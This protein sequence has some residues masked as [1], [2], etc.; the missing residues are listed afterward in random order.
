M[1]AAG[2]QSLDAADRAFI[3]KLPER[4]EVR[5]K[6]G[7]GG[8][9]V[10]F[11]AF[12]KKTKKK[13]ALKVLKE[14]GPAGRFRDRLAREF[15]VCQSIEHPNIVKIYDYSF[16]EGLAYLAMEQL[17]AKDLETILE[18]GELPLTKAVDIMVQVASA[19]EA[20]HGKGLVHR[21][22]KPENIMVQADGRAVLMDFNLVFAPDRTAITK[23]DEIV[24]TPAYFAPEVILQGTA[25]PPVD[26]YAL[27]LCFYETL[28]GSPAFE[29]GGLEQLVKAIMSDDVPCP[30]SIIPSLPK[31]VDRVVRRATAKHPEER[32]RSAAAFKAAL[33]SLLSPAARKTMTIEVVL[34]K[35]KRR[36]MSSNRRMTVALF[37]ALS[38]VFLLI[39]WRGPQEK[40][41]TELTQSPAVEGVAISWT[42]PAEHAF[43]IEILKAD[44]SSAWRS[45]PEPSTGFKHLFL[46][47]RKWWKP[48]YHGLITSA[49]SSQK[50]TFA[51]QQ[52]T[53]FKLQGPTKKHCRKG[54]W[55]KWRTSLPLKGEI[56]FEKAV[57]SGLPRIY[58]T[59]GKE[60]KV[61]IPARERIL[62]DHR[63]MLK[64]SDP[65]GG[66]TR[67][68]TETIK[69]VDLANFHD[70]VNRFRQ[71]D[72]LK[73]FLGK[74]VVQLKR[75]LLNRKRLLQSAKEV[76]PFSR[77]LFSSRALSTLD[78]SSLYSSLSFLRRVDMFLFASK[79]KPLF[80]WELSDKGYVAQGFTEKAPFDEGKWPPEVFL[81]RLRKGEQKFFP[82]P[83]EIDG[84]PT[85]KFVK[86]EVGAAA[87]RNFKFAFGPT[88]VD[89]LCF[90]DRAILY[91]HTRLK[92]P[93]TIL[94]IKINEALKVDLWE[95]ERSQASKERHYLVEMPAHLLDVNEIN[96]Q[97]ALI[98]SAK[99]TV[100]ADGIVFKIAFLP[101]PLHTWLDRFHRRAS[102]LVER[103][104]LSELQ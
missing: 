46:V 13:L 22:V 68:K 81:R 29:L 30:T 31:A 40:I 42:S 58:K 11:S 83:K 79:E 65:F 63:V 17:E 71:Q 19:L 69:A 103:I 95:A 1:V 16:D 8:F 12:D 75:E 92:F 86:S 50:T 9:S 85:I 26:I 64:V 72:G 18:K 94:T 47:P 38:L 78:Q 66:W 2:I 76:V 87:V 34:P 20:I 5:G 57:R 41:V 84:L 36:P 74:P 77:F 97:I 24:G 21:D 61:L 100:I 60:H 54:T 53:P 104:R 59:E 33:L 43:Q 3:E 101:G 91:L 15:K 99:H 62:R 37:M 7:S 45:P 93:D 90:G 49:E 48:A 52:L 98:P 56:I 80:G 6:L 27:G 10:V 35:V 82:L 73:V 4:Y 51:L 55:L 102:K 23:S 44:G 67:T 70:E 14:L 39:W 25:N 28:T 32:Y 96:V 89:D 88:W